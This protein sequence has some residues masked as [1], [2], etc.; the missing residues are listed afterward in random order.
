MIVLLDIHP[1][2]FASAHA[3][4]SFHLYIHA[5]VHVQEDRGTRCR[6]AYNSPGA[7]LNCINPLPS[8][9]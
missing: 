2:D 9:N 3:D 8:R 7:P 5:Y 1:K 4:M 6:R